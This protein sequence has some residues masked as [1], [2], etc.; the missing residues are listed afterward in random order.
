MCFFCYQVV[1]AKVVTSAKNPGS[2]CYGLVT[3]ATVE[4]ADNCIKQLNKTEFNGR[5]ISLEK[6]KSLAYFCHE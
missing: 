6:V 2:K 4:D 5:I 1:G 3:L